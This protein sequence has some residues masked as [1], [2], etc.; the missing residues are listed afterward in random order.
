MLDIHT[1]TQLQVH[2]EPVILI[3]YL[4]RHVVDNPQ[5][6]LQVLHYFLSLGEIGFPR[7]RRLFIL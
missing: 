5:G 3:L 7:D 1:Y 6:I 4:R 2:R